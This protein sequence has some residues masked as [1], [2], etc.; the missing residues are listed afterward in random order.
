LK[1]TSTERSGCSAIYSKVSERVTPGR[2]ELRGRGELT[3]TGILNALLRGAVFSCV[4]ATAPATGAE[5]PASVTG[6]KEVDALLAAMTLPEK[7]LLIRGTE[8]NSATNQGEAGYL[9]GIPR[10]GIPPLRMADGPPGVLTRIPSLA[11][12]ATMGLAATFSRKDARGNGEVIAREAKRVG[13]D[14]VLQPF[15][16]ID[17]DIAFSRGYNTFGEDPVL[18]GELGAAEI[19]GIQGLGVMAQAKHFVGYDT[20]GHD[21][22]IDQQ[23][24]HEVYLAPFADAVQAGVASIMCSYNKINGDWACENNTTL[25]KLLRDEL[26]FKGF[27]TSDWGAVHGNRA[28]NAGLDMEM[29]GLLAADSP[30]AGIMPSYFDTTPP[31]HGP[32]PPDFPRLSTMFEGLMPEEPKPPP[33]DWKVEFPLD[34]DPQNLWDAMRSAQVNTDTITQAAGRVLLQIKRFG[35][36]GRVG[37]R[38][39][40]R[41]AFTADDA[42][43]VQKT[44]EDAAVLL[45]NSGAVLPLGPDALRSVTLIG[46]GAGQ[47]VAIGK[48]GERSLGFPEQQVSPLEALRHLAP[49]GQGVGITYAVGDD[50]TGVLIPVT[51]L[52]HDGKPGLSRS[53]CN[54]GPQ[55]DGQIDFTVA[56]SASLPANSACRWTGTLTVPTAGSYWFYLQTLG[57]RGSLYIDGVRVGGSRSTTKALHGDI[58][59]ANEDGLLPTTDGLDNVRMAVDMKAGEHAVVVGLSGDTSNEPVQVRLNWST[60]AAR[61]SDHAAAIEAARHARTAIVFVWSRGYPAFSLPG[62]QNRLVMDVAA[63]NPN[64]I[65]VLNTSQ[66]VELPWIDQVKA[67]VQ[68]W[69]SGHA[70]GVAT[71]NVLTGRTNP[72]GRLPFTWARQLA[73][74]A[75]TDPAHPERS[76]H[77]VQ[78][79]TVFSEGVNVGYRWFD[80]QHLQPLYPFGFGLSYT[81]FVYDGLEIATAADGGLDVSFTL[82]NAGMTHGDEVPQLYLSAPARIP[83][84]VQFPSRALAGFDRVSLR[85]GERRVVRMHVPLRRLQYWSTTQG[86]W[87]TARR[88]R[89]LFV[90]ASSRDERLHAAVR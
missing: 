60:P 11:E 53:Q 89:T 20:D 46:P 64:T 49:D 40:G 58:V 78:G 50:M 27:V 6:D 15:I 55:V 36:L 9:S 41:G 4:L 83:A 77:G 29:P 71:A 35:L 43:S 57:A 3:L 17:R 54:A 23:T 66:P 28:I 33:V 72:A 24:L 59:Q 18:T 47:V 48:A 79:R 45:K 25:R 63:V 5:P 38:P 2:L 19:R 39:A 75:A 37:A 12:T 56:S 10:L 80:R 90:A 82:T 21:V 68:M 65:V 1:G 16:N 84:G 61:E 86:S 14:V 81:K 26:R 76:S 51:A 32:P 87:V 42:A 52:S 62:A 7:I 22:S 31:P 30:F 88:T 34:P 13:V 69:W 70:G 73:Q 8:E 85:A 74:Y 67:V 44:S